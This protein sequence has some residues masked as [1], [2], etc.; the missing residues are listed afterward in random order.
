M[1]P[2]RPAAA[3]QV[4][5]Q[6][7]SRGR[8]SA[9]ELQQAAGVSRATL[10][11]AVAADPSIVRL[12]NARATQY[13]LARELRGESRWPLYRLNAAAR[14]EHLGTLVSLERGEF[15]LIA[16]KYLPVLMHPQFERGVYPDVPWFLDDLR[17]NG[18]LGRTYAHRMADRLRVPADITR[19]NAEHVIV[20]LLHGGSTESGD[21]ILGEPSLERCLR[22]M[23]NPPDLVAAANRS[24]AYA[25]LAVQ[26][27]RGEQPGSSPGGEQAKFTA[28]V[29]T[30][31]G[32]YAAIVKFSAGEDGSGARRWASLLRCE[33]LAAAVLTERG[34]VAAETHIVENKGQVFLE[35]RRFDRT[36]AMGRRGFV[37]LAAIDAAFYGE[38][39][40]A[41]WRFAEML[42]RD[43]WLSADDATTLRRVSWFGA[44]I[45]NADMHLGNCGLMLTDEK[46][47]RLAP[48][49]DMLPMLL[50]P[51]SQGVV[52]DRSYTVPLPAAG[53]QAHWRWAAEAALDYWQR[54]L[55]DPS[56]DSGVQAFAREAE[57]EIREMA[58]RF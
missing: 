1:S 52:M 21:L 37:S 4:A 36:A 50:R 25:E 56:M 47:L 43:G 57:R 39:R 40:I 34:I 20:A 22:E 49:Y 51:S 54:V 9:A 45:A 10:A 35:S 41:W 27:L 18:F 33:A 11:R 38:A 31:D 8:L 44:L 46:P 53:Q 13:A 12:G 2:S 28:T 6:L 32:R 3:D 23:K 48:V 7:R 58:E 19:W 26:A 55:R 5:S 24:Q 30:H 16:Q 14:V 15:A 42:E 17:P 29:D